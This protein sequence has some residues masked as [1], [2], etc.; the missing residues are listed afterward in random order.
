MR[1]GC[2]CRPTTASPCCSPAPPWRR[3]RG[4]GRGGASGAPESA[5]SGGGAPRAGSPAEGQEDDERA[6][7]IGLGTPLRERLLAGF[8]HILVD[9]YQDINDDQYELLSL[10]AGRGQA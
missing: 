7:A 2:S 8:S 9:E 4:A 10:L 3:P 5:A 1:A 6:A